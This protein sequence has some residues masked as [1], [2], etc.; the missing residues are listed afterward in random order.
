M[1]VGKARYRLHTQTEKGYY[2]CDHKKYKYDCPYCGTRKPKVRKPKDCIH[3]MKISD[4]EK[5]RDRFCALH[6]Y[7]VCRRCVFGVCGHGFSVDHC[8]RKSYKCK[9]ETF[10]CE[11]C[12]TARKRK[13][14]FLECSHGKLIVECEP[15]RANY[16]TEHGHKSCIKCNFGFCDHGVRLYHCSSCTKPIL[17]LP[18]G[19]PKLVTLLFKPQCEHEIN[20]SDCEE[21]KDKYCKRHTKTSCIICKFNVCKHILTKCKECN[22]GYCPHGKSRNCIYCLGFDDNNIWAWINQE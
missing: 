11:E 20:I 9:H 22:F 17:C 21:C 4:C 1:P 8:P 15:C 7:K 18:C 12:G 3:K 19:Q 10:R 6:G 13:F 5:C 2:K 16:C 14:K